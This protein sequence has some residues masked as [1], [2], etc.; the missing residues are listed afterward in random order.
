[1][2]QATN[3][4]IQK[5]KDLGYEII[6]RRGKAIGG[7]MNRGLDPVTEIG[8]HWTGDQGEVTAK[9][10]MANY[11]SWWRQLWG[12]AN[13]GNNPTGGYGT[14]IPRVDNVIIVNYNLEVQTNGVGNQNGYTRHVS[15]VAG[16]NAPM[17]E[18]QRERLKNVLSTLV[19]LYPNVR[20]FDSVKGH[21]EFPGHASN[22]CPGIDMNAFRKYLK[23]GSNP[24]VSPKP[25]PE[26]PATAD[27]ANVPTSTGQQLHLP[28][29][30]QTWR[31]YNPSGP[32]TA[33]NEIH[34]LTPAAFGG[35][36][37]DIKGNPAPNVYL[38]DTGVRGRVAIY[39]GPETSARITGSNTSTPQRSNARQL[40]LPS[41]AQTWRIYRENGPYTVGNEIHK[42]TPAQFGGLTYDILEDKGNGVYIINTS[43]RGRV[44]IYADPNATSAR[45][46]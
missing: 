18:N 23:D 27:P 38:I 8:V 5:M 41:S 1:M 11:E 16:P 32:Y 43:V 44:A 14:L 13:N 9:N 21:K 7:T 31:I 17:T 46:T 20:S 4:F 28:A 2:S 30:A 19:E 37:Y 10:P 26:Q 34:K 6:D 25:A 45:I 24:D 3:T 42:L 15:Y 35:L 40:H 22:A 12:N 36:T 29:S 39:A 33:G